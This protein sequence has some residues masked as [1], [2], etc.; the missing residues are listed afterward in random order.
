M[1]VAHLASPRADGCLDAY[2]DPRDEPE[3][4]GEDRREEMPPVAHRLPQ[5]VSLA[6]AR[7]A[8][9]KDLLRFW[10]IDDRFDGFG[11]LQAAPLFL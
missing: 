4:A 9:R 6:P 7:L 3:P 2:R 11:N 10:I 5:E 1:A 8:E